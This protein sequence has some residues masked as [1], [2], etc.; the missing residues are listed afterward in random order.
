MQIKV[1]IGCKNDYVGCIYNSTNS[2]G[3]KNVSGLQLFANNT[4]NVN[5]LVVKMAASTL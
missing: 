4:Y 2:Y 1:C 5:M 3:C